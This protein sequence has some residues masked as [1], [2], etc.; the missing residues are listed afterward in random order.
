MHIFQEKFKE[1]GLNKEQSEKIASIFCHKLTLKK[2]EF[3]H[4]SGQL[5][6][7]I[8]LLTSGALRYYYDIDRTEI[9]RWVSLPGD[10]VTSL[11]SFMEQRVA[12]ESVSALQNSEIVYAKRE[13]WLLIYNS[14]P[15]LQNL[16]TKTIE[17]N[18][19]GME[20]RLYQTI[21]LTA[22]QR[23][24]W[25]LKEYPQFNIHIQDKYLASMLG[26][27]PRHLSRIRANYK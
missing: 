13:E 25:I 10:F 17:Q 14:E 16:W 12:S 26:I 6:D 1:L 11:S 4:K 9:T 20:N 7:K 15:F 24:E 27:T 8:G 19:I 2:G 3:F 21:A 22:E 23:Y 5:C 18:Y